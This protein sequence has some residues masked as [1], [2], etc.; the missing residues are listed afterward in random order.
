MKSKSGQMVQSP[1]G[2]RRLDC[3]GAAIGAARMNPDTAY[4]A[5]S[6]LLKEYI[7]NGSENAWSEIQQRIDNIYEAVSIA[8]EALDGEISF[9]GDIM[10]HLDMGKKLLFKPNMVSLPTIDPRTH[11]Q[12]LVGVCTPWEFVAA[13]MRW[14][15]DKRGITYHQMSMG[16]AGPRTSMVAAT[17]SKVFGGGTVTTQAIMEGKCGENYGG[18]G[19]YFTRKYLTDC[20]DTNHTDDPM[21]GYEESVSGVCLPPGTVNNR[22]L[23]YDLNKIARDFSNG[24]DVPVADGINYQTITLHKAIIGGDP[25]DP[26]DIHDWPGCVLVNV[27]KLKIHGI[28]LFTGA[29]KNLGIGLYP[30]ELNTSR[31]PGKFRWKYAM[32]NLEIPVLKMV[33]PHKRWTIESE[34][35]TGA[36]ARDKNGNYICR[37]TGGLE[38]TIADAVQAVRGQ[39]IMMLHVVDAIETTNINFTGGEGRTPVPEG[40]IF[41]GTD[42]VAVDVCA[43]RYLFNMVPM[44]EAD[45][46]CKEYNLTADVI[47]K[48]PMPR[49]EGANIVTGEG[50]DSSFS[51]YGA[52]KHW[53]DR[54]L[55]QQRF[56]VVG[57]DLWQDSSLASLRQHLG[58]VDDGVFSELLTTTLY[59]MP[60]KPLWDFQATC[61]A[62][63]ELNDK[64]TGSDFK[65]K[66]LEAYDENGDGIID[67]LE[68]GR[69]QSPLMSSHLMNLA[70]QDISPFEVLRLRFLIATAPLKRLKKEWNPDNH[71]FGEQMMMGQTLVKAFAMSKAKNEMPDPLFHG[72]T[73]GN[74]KWPSLQS[75]ML[76]QMFA[77]IYG[78]TYPDWFD[79]MLSPYGCSF[80]YAD[81]KWNGAK[82]CN[83]QAMAQNEG[84]IGSYHQAVEQ[85]SVLLPFTFY[86]P[87]GF[88][89]IGNTRVPNVEET[90]DPRLIFTASFSGKEVW[91]DLQLSSFHLK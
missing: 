44:A 89:S 19:F 85:G 69:E 10:K 83:A 30:T 52:L 48:V 11:G 47:Q 23:V 42:P 91:R 36:P 31:E 76:Q 2:K 73:W 86:V 62:Y 61:L 77:R 25:N 22:L 13:V 84:I 38:A 87:Q 34:E 18:W 28:E 78:Q 4:G 55:G 32:P 24:R 50:Y 20:H 35:E 5:I 1:I 26:R 90:D 79:L 33:V 41:A 14:F 56:Y 82:Y 45:E 9:S 37:K 17:T 88:G 53:E 60:N 16:E 75:A 81:T 3:T 70:I 49:M 67:Y 46:I 7:D 59:H 12:G 64:L 72:R 27:P 8:M 54:G 57:K 43:S 39:G 29:T 66:I 71:N 74:G 21:N 65:R 58:C 80:R 6:T 63:L 40:L 15:H 68:T 51:R